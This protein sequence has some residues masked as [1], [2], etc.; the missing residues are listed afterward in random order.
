MVG[1]RRKGVEKRKDYTSTLYV[2]RVRWIVFNCLYCA[3]Q[4]LDVANSNGP[5]MAINLGKL[6]EKRIGKKG[7]R[8]NNQLTRMHNF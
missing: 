4:Q 3:R 6:R 1:R 2:Y 8:K 5:Q 7:R